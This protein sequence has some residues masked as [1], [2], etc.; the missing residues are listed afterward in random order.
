MVTPLLKMAPL[1]LGTKIGQIW[2]HMTH[3]DPK[4]LVC[5]SGPWFRLLKSTLPSNF[6]EENYYDENGGLRATIAP[7]ILP[8]PGHPLL[9]F[10][11]TIVKVTKGVPLS[12]SSTT[13]DETVN[14]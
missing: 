9:G 7:Q 13:T 11:S 4:P 5:V 12:K 3:N 1:A 2:P 14:R 10:G 8:N 6:F